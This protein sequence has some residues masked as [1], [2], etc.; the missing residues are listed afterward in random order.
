ML[1][2]MQNMLQGADLSMSAW[3][4]KARITQLHDDNCSMGSPV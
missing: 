1:L 2:S 4:R 3:V